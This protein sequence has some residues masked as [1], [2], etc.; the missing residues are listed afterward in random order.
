MELALASFGPATPSGGAPMASATSVS[1]TSL[2]LLH[3]AVLGGAGELLAVGADGFDF[4]GVCHALLH[5]RGLGGA[6]QRLAV[7]A[8]GLGVA[9]VLGEGGPAGEGRERGNQQK[10][11]HELVSLGPTMR[12]M[13]AANLGAIKFRLRPITRNPVALT[14]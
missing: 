12:R 11:L 1:A 3:E 9:G 13:G 7:L 2:A 10:L 5:E 8:D 6:G 14:S 4:A